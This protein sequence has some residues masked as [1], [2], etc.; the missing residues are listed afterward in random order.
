MLWWTK[1]KMKRFSFQKQQASHPY[2]KNYEWHRLIGIY[3]IPFLLLIAITGALFPFGEK[4]FT[5]LGLETRKGPTLEQLMIETKKETFLPFTQL[6][7]DY[8]EATITQIRMPREDKQPI[9]FRLSYKYDLSQQ[10]TGNVRVWVNPYEG[11]VI[12]VVD[13]TKDKSFASVYQT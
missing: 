2:K 4:V 8:P 10:S 13:S 12:K 9:E 11:T 1:G 3:S 5:P 6:T 7:K